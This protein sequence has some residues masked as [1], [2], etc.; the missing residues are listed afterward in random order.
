M[1]SPPASRSRGGS[2]PHPPKFHSLDAN[3]EES[4]PSPRKR[5]H[6]ARLTPPVETSS[7]PSPSREEMDSFPIMPMVC[8]LSSSDDEEGFE[9][10]PDGITVLVPEA[11]RQ[12]EVWIAFSCT[13]SLD[14]IVVLFIAS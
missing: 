14:S 3:T 7:S 9:Q 1:Q 4:P 8:Q 11:Q 5:D 13:I 6:V 10:H 2:N 12:L